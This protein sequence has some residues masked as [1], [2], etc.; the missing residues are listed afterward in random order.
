MAMS[1]RVNAT[2]ASREKINALIIQIN[3]ATTLKSYL[4]TK[5]D[6]SM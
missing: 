3:I 6:I 4:I 2:K 5:I 1:A